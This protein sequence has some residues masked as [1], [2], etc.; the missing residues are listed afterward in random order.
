MLTYFKIQRVTIRDRRR[1]TK[2]GRLV[3]WKG[4]RKQWRR[5]AWPRRPYPVIRKTCCAILS[6]SGEA[7]CWRPIRSRASVI[8]MEMDNF[9]VVNSAIPSGLFERCMHLWRTNVYLV[10]KLHVNLCTFDELLNFEEFIRCDPLV[11]RHDHWSVDL[12]SCLL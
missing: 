1:R 9:D 7:E 4:G 12:T 8:Q 3:P 10:V 2:D 11:S 5:K 6:W